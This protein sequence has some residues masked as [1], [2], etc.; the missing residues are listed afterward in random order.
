MKRSDF[1]KLHCVCLLILI[2]NLSPTFAQE[3]KDSK[4]EDTT[5]R[6]EAVKEQCK[7]IPL[8]KRIRL[9]V[10]RFTSTAGNSP[11]EL[12]ENMSTM[13]SS[14]LSQVNCFNVLEEKKNMD[15]MTGEIE[16]ANSEYTNAA[17]GIEK[18]Q[19]KI[20]QIVVTGEVTEYNDAT[21]STG[22][23]GIS[24][25][26]S[27]AKIGFVLKVINPRTR[28]ILKATSFNVETKKGSASS[29]KFVG[30]KMSNKASSNPAVAAALEQGIV[31][32]VEY[33]AAEKDNI[34]LPSAEEL[35]S[36]LTMVTV[37]NV[38][39]SQKSTTLDMIKNT[40]GVKNAEL[41]NFSNNVATYTVKHNGSTD[42]LAT[43][44][45]KKYS[46]KFE[47]N[48]AKSGKISMRMK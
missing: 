43:L 27:K 29:F 42:D 17:T 21:Q 12:G 6:M 20:A 26:T 10:A 23:M 36:N 38:T 19:M 45:D 4:K 41:S 28:E 16:L 37:S 46:S 32:A 39:F 30:I 33:L 48:E 18:G 7:D 15:D 44:I 8:D 35:N 47:I 1:L 5:V 40:S 2:S 9:T 14:A 13:L 25:S 3:K 24:S 11:K 31:Q 34:P 22:T